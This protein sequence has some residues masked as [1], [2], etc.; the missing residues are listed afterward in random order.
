MEKGSSRDS[1]ILNPPFRYEEEPISDF[2]IQHHIG[3]FKKTAIAVAI[4][5]FHLL[6]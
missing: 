1:P 4:S 3:P 2:H 5:V 6:K